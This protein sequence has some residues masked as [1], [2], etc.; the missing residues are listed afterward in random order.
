MQGADALLLGRRTYVIH[1]RTFEPIPPFNCTWTTRKPESIS[2]QRCSG[3]GID[4]RPS[5]RLL[6][7]RKECYHR[8]L[9]Q[10]A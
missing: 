1:A 3:T 8:A 6:P 9:R 2:R 7:E 10:R 4:K 5:V